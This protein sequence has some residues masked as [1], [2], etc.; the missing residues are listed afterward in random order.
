MISMLCLLLAGV[1]TAFAVGMYRYH[2]AV[3]LAGPVRDNATDGFVLMDNDDG[4]KKRG[5]KLPWTRG[6]MA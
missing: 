5:W 4:R 6:Q 2:R 3:V 1:Y